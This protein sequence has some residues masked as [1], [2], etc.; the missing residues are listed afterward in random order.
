MRWRRSAAEPRR[1]SCRSADTGSMLV[2]LELQAVAHRGKVD[3]F[4]CRQAVALLA[5]LA[6][7]KVAGRD[8][9][10]AGRI[11]DADDLGGPRLLDHGIPI[12][13][14]ELEP[15]VLVAEG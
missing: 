1:A 13:V 14:D 4:L 11:V 15:A 10:A 7:G 3:Q 2:G 5:F 8:I 6:L 12:E 9:L